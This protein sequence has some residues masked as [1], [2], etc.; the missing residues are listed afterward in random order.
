MYAHNVG[1]VQNRTTMMTYPIPAHNVHDGQTRTVM[2]TYLIPAP[3]RVPHDVDDGWEA[4]SAGVG[5]VVSLLHE[6]V[7]FPSYLHRYRLGHAKYQ[8]GA[9]GESGLC[10][11][12]C[13]SWG[14][15]DWVDLWQYLHQRGDIGESKFVTLSASTGVGE[16][17]LCDSI[18][19]LHHMGDVGDSRFVTTSASTWVG[20]SVLCDSICTSWGMLER[21]DCVTVSAS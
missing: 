3:S 5:G 12:I 7:V 1:D 13:I 21:A 8:L 6:V 20:E 14:R 11:S 10:D 4:G 9:V 17:G 18:C 16:S 19:N 2:M 15:L